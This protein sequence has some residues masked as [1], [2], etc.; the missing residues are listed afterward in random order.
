ME[1]ISA[2]LLFG[3]LYSFTDAWH[4]EKV[5][6]KLDEWHVIDAG[7][8]AFVSL[9]IS[10]TIYYFT[11][12]WMLS[13]LVFA[14]IIA[15]RKWTFNFFLDRLMGWGKNRRKKGFDKIPDWTGLVLIVAIIIY[16]YLKY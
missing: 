11:F 2:A 10:L 4:D 5:I 8:K 12:D 15:S 7:I 14:T 6:N 13:V 3:I 16:A 9:A 1:L